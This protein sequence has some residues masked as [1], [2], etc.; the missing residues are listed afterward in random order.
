M[1]GKIVIARFLLTRRQSLQ[2]YQLVVLPT[3]VVYSLQGSEWQRRASVCHCEEFD[4][5]AILESAV[6]TSQ[7]SARAVLAG[8]VCHPDL[9]T[10]CHVV[11][12]LAMTVI[13]LG[14]V[15]EHD[16]FRQHDGIDGQSP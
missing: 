8:S 9:D 3:D 4:D 12:L 13:H 15:R 5:V 1:G 10:D 16:L 14:G 7:S 2:K 6:E 11:E